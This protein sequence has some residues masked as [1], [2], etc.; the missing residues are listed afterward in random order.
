MKKQAVLL[1]MAGVLAAGGLAATSEVFATTAPHAQATQT[2]A[3]MTMQPT[4]Q[5][6][7]TA[8][9]PAAQVK[10]V[11]IVPHE[12]GAHD[13]CAYCNMTVYPKDHKMGAFTAQVQLADG[14]HLFLDDVG[15]LLNFM[16]MQ[17]TP[18]K[19]A[20]VRDFNT[21][22]WIPY[23]KAIPVSA[24]IQTPMRYGIGLFKDNASAQA[25]IRANTQKK[26]VKTSWD[27]INLEAF[28]RYQMKMQKMQ[29]HKNTS[30]PMQGHG[31][32]SH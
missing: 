1:T 29:Q 24:A 2:N 16:R 28:K 15:C 25:F 22:E 8:A 30:T 10:A 3:H 19:G 5:P 21:K 7:A 18:P 32:T 20:W 17:K 11:Q 13:M 31:M 6:K 9:T 14:R 26:A 27:A 12:P 4:V 23:Q